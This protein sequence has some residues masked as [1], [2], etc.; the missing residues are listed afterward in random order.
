MR[1]VSLPEDEGSH[2]DARYEWWY[3]AAWLSAASGERYHYTSALMRSPWGW[4]C[5]YRWWAEESETP[6]VVVQ[7]T[8]VVLHQPVQESNGTTTIFRPRNRWTVRIGPGYS[9]HAL[10]PT[11]IRLTDDHDRGACLHTSAEDGGIVSFGPGLEM[12]WYSWPALGASGRLH[13]GNDPRDELT[14]FGWME[15]QWGNTDFTKLVWRYLPIVLDDGRRYIAYGIDGPGGDTGDHVLS[16]RD[17]VAKPTGGSFQRRPA[18]PL[19]TPVQLPDLA[20]QVRSRDH[21]GIDLGLPTAIVPPF[22][23]GPSVVL[24]AA[25]RAVGVAMTEIMPKE[26]T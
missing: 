18:D 7:N 23:E 6:S 17:G 13:D 20:C 25:G 22:W 19:V 8:P 1:H 15:H 24:D 26:A 4:S 21:A 16:L 12:A 10:G 14:G 9:N 11:R 2:F 3:F 5:Y